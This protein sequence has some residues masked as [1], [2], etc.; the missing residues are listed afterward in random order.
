MQIDACRMRLVAVC[1]RLQTKFDMA[2]AS[3]LNDSQIDY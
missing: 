3:R 1:I 2:V